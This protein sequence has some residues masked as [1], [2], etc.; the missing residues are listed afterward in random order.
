[1]KMGDSRLPRS[2]AAYFAGLLIVAG[3]LVLG[4][5]VTRVCGLDGR[6]APAV[7]LAALIALATL[8]VQLPGDATL[9]AVVCGLAVV[10][11]AVWLVRGRRVRLDLP[12]AGA[13]AIAAVLTT[14][15]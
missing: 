13:A 10:A 2:M 1:M 3:A 7:G 15:P 5:A 14:V 6:T 12:A 8:A 4:H 11:A 9:A